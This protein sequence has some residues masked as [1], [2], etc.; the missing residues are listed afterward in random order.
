MKRYLFLGTMLIII[1]LHMNVFAQVRKEQIVEIGESIKIKS[2]V[3]NEDRKILIYLPEGYKDSTTRYP[4]LYALDGN[5]YFMASIGILKYHA[6][7]DTV[8]E[9]I[10]VAIPNTSRQ[11]DFTPTKT[12][13]SPVSGGVAISL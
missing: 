1:A 12:D 6:E 9:M 13:Y 10:I 8:P 11:R 5:T 3:L 7:F 4:V 2:K